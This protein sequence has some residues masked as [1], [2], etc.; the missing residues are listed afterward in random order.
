[1]TAAGVDWQMNVYGEAGH[2]FT[3]PRSG[4]LGMPGFAYHPETDRRSWVAMI[5]LFDQTLGVVRAA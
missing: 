4:D 3:N 1:M 2:S 5:D